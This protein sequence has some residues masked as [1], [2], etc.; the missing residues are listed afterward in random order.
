[1]DVAIFVEDQASGVG[2]IIKDTQ[3]HF[4]AAKSQKLYGEVD[5]YRAEIIVAKES[6]LF[7]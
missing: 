2:I 6:L 3:G 1:M 5:G 4:V 7:A